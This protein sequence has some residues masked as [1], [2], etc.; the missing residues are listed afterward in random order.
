MFRKLKERASIFVVKNPSLAILLSILILNLALFAGAAAVISWLAPKSLANSGFW[1]SVYYTITMILDAGCIDN[2]IAD[3]GE[4]SV[5]LII[6]CIAIVIVGMITFTGAV[7]GYVT[8][9]ISS[10]IENSQ[11][12]NRAL[13]VSGHTVIL[14]WNSRAS[15][16]INDLMYTGK[17]ETVVV[18]ASQKT[19]EIEH[20]VGERLSASLRKD[21]LSLKKECEQ[22]SGLKRAVYYWKHRTKNRLTVVIREGETFSTKQLNDISISQASNV[23]LLTKDEQNELCRFGSIERRE[24]LAK[25]NANTIK[26]LV[27]VAEMTSSEDSADHQTIIVEVEDNWTAALVDRIVAHKE[28]LAK[29]HIIPVYV[30]RVLGQILSQFSIM[31]ELNTVY[32]ELFSNRGAEFFFK[33]QTM[34]DNVNRATEEYMLTHRHAIPLT[35]METASGSYA[36]SVANSEA[37]CDR[38]CE[39]SPLSRTFQVNAAYHLMP[40]NVVIIGHNSKCADIMNGFS[41]F[42]GEHNLEGSEIINI[43]VIDDEKSLERLNYYRDYPYVTKTVTADVYDAALIRSA[44]EEA[45]DSH[46]GDTSLLILSDDYTASEDVDSAALTHLIYVQDI[47]F[48]RQKN[49]DFDRESID[50]IVEIL[51]PK[52]YDVVHNYSVDNVVISNRYISK[53]VTQIGRKQALFEFYSDILTYDEENA[54]TYE[55]KELYVKEVSQF[56]CEGEIPSRCT[57]RELILGVFRASPEDNKAIVLGYTSP[58]GKMVLFSGDQDNIEVALTAADKLIVFSNH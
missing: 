11:S 34:E 51:N 8:N 6:V 42:R 38:V 45:I 7:V 55:S 9:Y 32:S 57:A 47:I 21:Q 29:C 3:I 17:R 26:T 49:P 44:I 35:V 54:D 33:P 14:N 30:N 22:F 36:F 40:R 39:S 46:Q 31:P 18:L 10:F 43:T 41:A 28:K 48:D 50:V 24:E 23:I 4:A 13:K 2:V 1:V 20:E 56:F 12:G 27:Q 58:G 16:I 15:E 37:D 53:M 25:G 19:D 5:G 52:N